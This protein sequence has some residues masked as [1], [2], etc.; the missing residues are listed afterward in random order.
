MFISVENVWSPYKKSKTTRA[1]SL[2]QDL[3][4]HVNH[5]PIHLVTLKGGAKCTEDGGKY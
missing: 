5:S 1:A 4:I 2:G 3:S